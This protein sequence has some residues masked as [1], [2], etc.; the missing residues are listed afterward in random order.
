MSELASGTGPHILLL[1]GPNMNY[2]GKRQPELYGSTTA[3]QLDEMVRQHALETGY[4]LSIFYTNSEGAA[5]DRIYEA[6]ENEGMDGLVMNPASWSVAAGSSIRYC[7]MSV[8]KPYVEIHLRNQYVMKNVSTLADLAVGVVQGFGI[9][10]YM[11]GL[12]AMYRHLTRAQ[13][14]QT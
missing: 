8:A 3:A 5:L 11:L 2:L 12:D 14:D 13:A 10:S 4:R 7:I 1:Q 6:V 9:D